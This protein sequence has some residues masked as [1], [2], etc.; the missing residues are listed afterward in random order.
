MSGWL[1]TVWDAWWFWC[2]RSYLCG[3]AAKRRPDVRGVPDWR[4]E[5]RPIGTA[6]MGTDCGMIHGFPFPGIRILWRL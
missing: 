2:T 1:L 3:A 5:G 4:P 6:L